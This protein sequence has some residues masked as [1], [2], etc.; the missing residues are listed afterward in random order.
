M[1]SARLLGL[2]PRIPC[3]C[4]LAAACS[5]DPPTLGSSSTGGGA[6]GSATGGTAAGT[7][8]SASAVTG[9]T[10]AT[11]GSSSGATSSSSSGGG[12]PSGGG[13]P[14]GGTHASGGEQATGG[15]AAGGAGGSTGGTTEPAPTGGVAG[16]GGSSSLSGAG[17]VDDDSGGAGPTA[18]MGTG[19]VLVCPSAACGNT[20]RQ[21]ERCT[22]TDSVGLGKYQILTNLWGAKGTAE[23]DGQCTWTLCESGGK[24]AWGTEFTWTSGDEISVKSF[25]AAILGWHWSDIP[26]GTGL[27]VQL[28]QDR[29]IPCTWS[30]Q[31]DVDDA[32]SLN[33]AWDLWLSTESSPSQFTSPSDEIMVWVDRQNKEDPIGYEEGVQDTVAIGDAEWELYRGN[34]GGNEVYSYLRKPSAQ[35]ATLDLNDFLQDLVGRGWVDASKYLI[36]IE[37]GP[38]VVRGKGQVVTETYS[39]DVQ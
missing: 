3:V 10:P 25:A 6:Y 32:A 30:F 34:N 2:F 11:G 21:N 22:D 19:G 20:Q 12:P 27:P 13:S 38:E 31:L 29:R 39:C 35:C 23:S 36:S 1:R 33:V 7:G 14:T 15:A 24:I 17:G 18:G 9:G 26:Q 8:A 28:S 4:G 37:S 5:S 16:T